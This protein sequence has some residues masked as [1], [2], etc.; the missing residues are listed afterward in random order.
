M[1]TSFWSYPGTWIAIAVTLVLVAGGITMAVV[2]RRILNKPPVDPTSPTAPS[3]PSE[4][5]RPHE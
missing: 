4:K 5:N 1:E 2:L 3:T